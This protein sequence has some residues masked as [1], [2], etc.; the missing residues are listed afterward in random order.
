MTN[1]A[2]NLI[3]AFSREELALLRQQ[4]IYAAEQQQRERR[5]P[6]QRLTFRDLARLLHWQICYTTLAQATAAALRGQPSFTLPSAGSA[7]LTFLRCERCRAES[8]L[9]HLEDKVLP[10]E[11]KQDL[12]RHL[13]TEAR[14]YSLLLDHL[15]GE[16]A[17]ATPD[18]MIPLLFV[19]VPKTLSR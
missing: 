5:W 14:L 4:L 2:L 12:I 18:E 17:A 15:T 7:W 13:E 1:S 19:S 16:P 9:H 10:D 3:D 6:R 8:A 11:I